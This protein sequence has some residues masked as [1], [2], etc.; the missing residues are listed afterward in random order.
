MFQ[1][2]ALNTSEA[3]DCT[4]ISASPLT[5]LTVTVVGLTGAVLSLTWKVAVPPSGTVT[6]SALVRMAGAA[7][8][9]VDF[10]FHHVEPAH[11]RC[12]TCRSAASTALGS[13][14]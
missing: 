8:S 2:E 6:A 4:V 13:P 12:C 10:P 11:W 5:R 9:P 1:L 14:G 7:A 3:P